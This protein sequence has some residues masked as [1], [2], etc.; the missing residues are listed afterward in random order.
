[1]GQ[2]SFTDILVKIVEDMNLCASKVYTEGQ[3]KWFYVTYMDPCEGGYQPQTPFL[4]IERLLHKMRRRQ[5]L[6]PHNALANITLTD[7]KVMVTW[8][9]GGKSHYSCNDPDLPTKIEKTLKKIVKKDVG[10]VQNV[11]L[12]ADTIQKISNK[13]LHGID[14]K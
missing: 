3:N 7:G 13:I 9:S 10:V 12:Q 4:S 8:W 11:F 6:S 5:G 14:P 1:M 2:P